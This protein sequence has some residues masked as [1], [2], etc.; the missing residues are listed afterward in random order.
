MW[1]FLQ[2]FS[3]LQVGTLKD[4]TP[5]YTIHTVIELIF[6]MTLILYITLFHFSTS[7][8]IHGFVKFIL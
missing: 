8:F 5:V 7:I 6:G 1:L 3:N 4:V 2:F